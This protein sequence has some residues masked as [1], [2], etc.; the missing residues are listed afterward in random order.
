MLPKVSVII[1]VFNAEKTLR[2]CLDSVV[3]LDY[4]KEKLEIVCVD[5]GSEDGSREIIR[6]Y[7]VVYA[8]E[9]KK[10]SYAAR[11]KGI[12]VSTGEV[13][14]FTD[15]DCIVDKDW[16]K[17]GISEMM[18]EKADIVGGTIFACEPETVVERYLDFMGSLSTDRSY[19]D[20]YFP[21]CNVLIK[22]GAVIDVKGFDEDFITG[23]DLDFSW[24]CLA[25]GYRFIH[26][27]DI[28]VNHKHRTNLLDMYGQYFKYGYSKY[29]LKEKYSR[30][31][32]EFY[33]EYFHRQRK[34]SQWKN[35]CSSALRLPFAMTLE[36]RGIQKI[37]PFFTLLRQTAM[38]TGELYAQ[39]KNRNNAK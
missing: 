1:P 35:I 21:T 12:A 3:N 4:P 7:P 25:K 23:G 26:S 24:R 17:N 39:V 33:R 15:S 13:L 19:R 34:R 9:E 16:I 38:I 22:R 37:Y 6:E 29:C 27:K 18:K 20:R 10:T 30:H 36:G 32:D 31:A 28:I 2:L 11:N 5:N 8:C 14:A